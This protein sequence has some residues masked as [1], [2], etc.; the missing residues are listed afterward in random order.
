[1][2]PLSN[3]SLLL[4]LQFILQVQLTLAKDIPFV[5]PV[6]NYNTSNYNAGNQNWAIAQDMNEIMYFANN[7]GLLCFDG[8]NW[9]LHTLPNN[10]GVKSIFI[11]SNEDNTNSERIYVGSFEEFGYFE[12]DATNRL[13]YHSLKHLVKDYTFKNDEIWTI[14]KYQETVYFQSFSSYFSYSKN[15]ITPHTSNPAPLFFFNLQNKLYGQLIKDGLF[16]FNKDRYDR[17]I[18][19]SQLANDDVVGMISIKNDFI[20]I[21][22]RS[23]LFNFNPKDNVVDKWNTSVDAELHSAIVNRVIPVSDSLFVLGTINNGLY[24]INHK[25]DIEWHI[26]RKN[27][28]NNNTVLG[29][30]KDKAGTLWAALDN[31][32]SNIQVNSY[33]SIFEP[34]DIQI[35]MVEDILMTDNKTYVA[36]NQGV[37]MYNPN[38]ESFTQL[39]DFNIQTWYIKKIDN[40]IIA[41]H[42]K[43]ASFIE[44]DKHLL[45]KGSSIGGT[46]IKEARI[47]G[48]DALIE[49]TYS[50]LSI[51]MK[52]QTDRWTFSHNIT[53]GYVDLARHI[54]IDHTGNIWVSHMYKG[55]YRLRKSF[56]SL[57]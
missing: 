7:Q 56:L 19:R 28:L 20:L 14:L 44:N 34:S 23:G 30:Y 55:I 39:T 38:I 52:D 12:R 1:M 13:F 32:I 37:Y 35:G 22:S 33:V 10:Q 15:T 36:T 31:G 49:S 54:E 27:G 46:D 42:N 24:A 43:G 29:L 4:L 16:Q 51:F 50:Y 53:D 26:N 2:N 9:S 57:N 41:G 48:K 40:Q 45:I 11:D 8:I 6:F 21:T 17:I 47:N 5:P 18:D 25:G 3:F